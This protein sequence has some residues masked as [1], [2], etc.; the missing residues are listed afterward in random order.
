MLMLFDSSISPNR[1]LP[2]HL[3]TSL[4]NFQAKIRPIFDS[5]ACF[6]DS[7]AQDQVQVIAKC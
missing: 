4:V 1:Y 2:K 3:V 7:Y 5:G 6:P